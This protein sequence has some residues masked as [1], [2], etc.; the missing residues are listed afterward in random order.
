[1]IFILDNENTWNTT[2]RCL[3]PRTS[4]TR[5]RCGIRRYDRV[6]DARRTRTTPFVG[7]RDVAR[8]V[9]QYGWPRCA[10]DPSLVYWVFDVPPPSTLSPSSRVVGL[11]RGRAEHALDTERRWH[12]RGH[13]GHWVRKTRGNPFVLLFFCWRMRCVMLLSANT[14]P[15]LIRSFRFDDLFITT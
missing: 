6:P 12:H 5:R 4:P 14:L 7:L 1:M 10:V 8:L 11:T 3:S 9:D 13:T 15:T 2:R